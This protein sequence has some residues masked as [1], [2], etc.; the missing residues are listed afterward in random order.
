MLG[1]KMHVQL[2]WTAE[3]FG[4]GI[5]RVARGELLSRQVSVTRMSLLSILLALLMLSNTHSSISSFLSFSLL[6]GIRGFDAAP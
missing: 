4:D 6:T 2:N 5:D 3:S 1:V